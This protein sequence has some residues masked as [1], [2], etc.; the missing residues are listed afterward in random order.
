[1]VPAESVSFCTSHSP[2]VRPWFGHWHSEEL[3]EHLVLPSAIFTPNADIWRDQTLYSR[4]QIKS[5]LFLLASK[6][7]FLGFCE[8]VNLCDYKHSI[9]PLTSATQGYQNEGMGP[10]ST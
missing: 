2:A 4:S 3:S 7:Q 1:M 8:L 10:R 5:V 6:Q 9:V